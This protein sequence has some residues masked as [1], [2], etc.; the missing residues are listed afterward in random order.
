[1]PTVSTAHVNR[2]TRSNR[3]LP[4]R[5]RE[6]LFFRAHT[7]AYALWPRIPRRSNSSV[8]C[9]M[10]SRMRTIHLRGRERNLS[11]FFFFSKAKKSFFLEKGILQV[12]FVDV[13]RS[14]L[15]SFETMFQLVELYFCGISIRKRVAASLRES[16]LTCVQ[17]II[18]SRNVRLSRY[19]LQQTLNSC[20]RFMLNVKT[21]DIIPVDSSISYKDL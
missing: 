12:V 5:T 20:L 13:R 4:S 17:R 11:N 19:K 3:H 9:K 7:C 18:I 10:R 16:V 21:H 14:R 8:F 15:A 2:A 1:M 6:R